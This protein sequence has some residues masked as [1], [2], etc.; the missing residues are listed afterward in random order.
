MNY[1]ESLNYIQQ[2]N[3][4]KISPQSLIDMK[5]SCKFLSLLST[6]QDA[7]LKLNNFLFLFLSDHYWKHKIISK[8]T[9]L[10]FLKC[11]VE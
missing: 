11:S 10:N 8:I 4:K 9:H 2:T 3:E 5:I 1:N 6:N 7:V